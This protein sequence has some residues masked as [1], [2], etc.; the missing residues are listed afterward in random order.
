MPAKS[1]ADKAEEQRKA[2]EA[3]A[4]SKIAQK[5]AEERAKEA[6][7]KA[8]NQAAASADAAEAKAAAAKAVAEKA[9]TNK[10]EPVKMVHAV[11]KKVPNCGFISDNGHRIPITRVGQVLKLPF[12]TVS[13]FTEF[14]EPGE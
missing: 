5:Q 9:A 4:Q 12:G 3:E 11:V 7:E 10:A 13:C 14:L 1:A 8:A 2:K 6:A